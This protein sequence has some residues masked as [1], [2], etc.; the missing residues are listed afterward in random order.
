V[1]AATRQEAVSRRETIEACHNLLLRYQ[2]LAD[3]GPRAELA[4]LFTADV[5]FA[6]TSYDRQFAGCD[7]RGQRALHDFFTRPRT[8]VPSFERHH[9]TDVSV[10]ITADGAALS[11]HF[12][13]VQDSGRG[14]TIQGGDYH[15]AFR[16]EIQTWRICVALAYVSWRWPLTTSD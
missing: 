7:V 13:H 10:E 1:A 6:I 16:H 3:E 4:A 2:A 14:R 9:A 5:H 11:A 12:I 15:W 8:D